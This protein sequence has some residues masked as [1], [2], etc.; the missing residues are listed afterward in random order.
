M[1]KSK[2][3]ATSYG[4]YSYTGKSASSFWYDDYETNYDYLGEYGGYE[5]KDLDAYKRTNNLYKLSSVRRA[6][7]NFVQ[8]V[9]NKSIP[10]TFATKSESK[11]DG[12]KVILSADVDDNFDVSVGLALHEGSHIV[13][14]DFKL[15][16]AM[17]KCR[18]RYTSSARSIKIQNERAIANG[19]VA[20]FANPVA[21]LDRVMVD[22]I[23]VFPKY[24]KQLRSIFLS[25]GKIGS[26][27]VLTEEV[28]DTISG[29]T[30]WIE[31][32]RIDM[33][34]YKSA[35]GYRDYYTSMYDHYFNDKIVTKGIASDEFT[36]ETI[37]SYM[38][39]I[40]NL[41]NENTQ[42]SKLKGLRAI[43]RMLDL[44]NI[45][46]LN[47]SGDA[48]NVAIDVMAEIL[49]NVM[50]QNGGQM[51]QSGAGKGA[52]GDTGTGEETE[53]ESGDSNGGSEDGIAPTGMGDDK[54]DD[55][56]GNSM[57]ADGDTPAD[58]TN[59]KP[60]ND[61]KLSKNAAQQL[62]KKFQ[63]QKDFLNGNLKKKSVSK[64]EINKLS[65]IQESESE[66]VRV[67]SDIK[68]GWS[69][70]IGQGVDCIVVK[71]LT[72]NL[73]KSDDFPFASKDWSSKEPQ[74][75]A[76]DEVKRG[77]TLGTILG[78]KLQ[79]R[80]ESRE[81]IFSRL[82]KGRIDKRMVASLGYDN[83]SVFYTN[84]IDQYKKAN[85]HIS[86]DYSGSMS[87]R[88]L[89]KTITSV[90][91]IVKACEMARN[92]NVQVSI[93]STDNGRGGKSLPYICLIHDSRR[94]SFKQFAKYM[95]ILDCSNTTPEGLC[96][97]AIH[98]Y[99]IPTDNSVDSYFLNFSDGQPC[100]NINSK[101]DSISYSGHSAAEH[102]NKQVKKMRDSGMNV[103]SYFIT[104]RASDRFE[105]SNDWDIFKK[106]YDKSAKYVDVE[107]VMQVAKTMNDLF[108]QKANRD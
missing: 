49:T 104:E 39:R 4:K 9:T 75:W 100:Y 55:N 62:A 85:L 83:D 74:V 34:I 32:R 68:D 1:S 28:V 57:A 30:N 3:Q 38:F 60:G 44:K 87:G 78:K 93:R 105:S 35:P 108:L 69:G 103:L 106:S 18:E 45:N 29:L 65:D 58:I 26:K 16:G 86:L 24:D 20:P 33:Y 102:T 42:L 71:K 98:K 51:P 7:A 52:G 88:K 22:Q 10:V 61:G 94:D 5:K 101:T 79:I 47:N 92:L 46:R 37:E 84:E 12:E 48:L 107:N 21:E 72:S 90:V 80:S 25:D 82:K 2:K 11:T 6:I 96:F 43:Y 73:L 56:G 40:I 77:I 70:K 17:S 89:K 13:L 14:S 54:G 8:I 95:S 23:K 15:L 31:D 91:A 50:A 76:E 59:P 81:T 63:K 67:G 99:L 64:E 53:N 36:D 97:E 66:L 41:M 27:G 19:E